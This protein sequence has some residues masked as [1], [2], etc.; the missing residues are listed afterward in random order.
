MYYNETL[1]ELKNWVI[2]WG[3]CWFFFFIFHFKYIKNL[4]HL[5]RIKYPQNQY[6]YGIMYTENVNS[7]WKGWNNTRTD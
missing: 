5:T 6:E 7:N 3:F 4:K 2:V 1:I